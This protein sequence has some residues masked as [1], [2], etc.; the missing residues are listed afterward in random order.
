MSEIRYLALLGLILVGGARAGES[1][2]ASASAGFPDQMQ[3]CS[4]AQNQAERIARDHFRSAINAGGSVSIGGKRC[5][6]SK[7]NRY[8]PPQY[9]CI[10]YVTGQVEDLAGFD[11]SRCIRSLT[12]NPDPMT[13][14]GR[15]AGY[16]TCVRRQPGYNRGW[17]TQSMQAVRDQL[18]SETK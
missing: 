6:C 5:D 18:R 17:D 9:E 10:G 2:E 7:N 1:Y 3:S 8:S 13:W 4:A 15:M 14:T 12:E 16:L 11:D